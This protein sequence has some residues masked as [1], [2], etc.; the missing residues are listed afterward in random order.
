MPTLDE[1][2]ADLRV[3]P[4]FA[5]LD[6]AQLRSLAEIARPVTL[7]P[8]STIFL[9]GDSAHALYLLAEGRVKVFKL[10]RDGRT[11]T[12][13]HVDP[14]MTFAEAALFQDAY[15]ASTE[16]MTECRLYR[17]ETED[18]LGLLAAQ[19]QLAV[20]MIASMAYLLGLLNRR[21]EEL[22]LPVPARLARYLLA[23]ADEQLDLGR[24]VSMDAGGRT[25]PRPDGARGAAEPAPRPASPLPDHPRVVKLP[26]SK[27]EL[28][29]R[30]GT[31]PETLSRT[32][33]R[34]KRA[35]VIRM[36]GDHELIE[37]LSFEKL[38]RLAQN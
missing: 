21:V 15:P 28:A 6:D 20:N 3:S 23:L 36:S 32:F 7:P 13:R 29:A 37:I 33:D 34:L 38:H 8:E 30:L 18:M 9:Q 17:W 1:I 12:V 10:L 24:D 11:A 22:L 2:I 31:V 25:G 5:R 14:G 16:T 27:R 26:T 4:T 35:E 19:P